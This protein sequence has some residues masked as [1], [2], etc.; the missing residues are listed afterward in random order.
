M[1]EKLIL[2]DELRSL[3]SLLKTRTEK[4]EKYQKALNEIANEDLDYIRK[5]PSVIKEIARKVL[6]KGETK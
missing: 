2:M 5:Q 6:E 3:Y 1:S 4:I